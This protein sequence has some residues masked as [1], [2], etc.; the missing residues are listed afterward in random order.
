MVHE[1]KAAGLEGGQ[2]GGRLRE[3]PLVG[4]DAVR[5]GPQQMLHI[6]FLYG[7]VAE[8]TGGVV[9]AWCCDGHKVVTDGIKA[10]PTRSPRSATSS[11]RVRSR[12]RFDPHGGMR[13]RVLRQ[14]V[15]FCCARYPVGS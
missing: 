8:W 11:R 12:G 3:G 6:H 5:A 13:A 14:V 15:S 7:I 1:P 9:W 2:G 10:I 4:S